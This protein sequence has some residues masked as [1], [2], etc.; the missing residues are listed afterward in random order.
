MRGQAF[1]EFI[2]DT[3]QLYLKEIV[4][5]GFLLHLR[6]CMLQC[7]KLQHHADHSFR[8][9]LRKSLAKADSVPAKERRI[10][11]RVSGLAAWRQ[12]I[13]RVAVESLWDEFVMI[14]APL[15]LVMVQKCILDVNLVTSAHLELFCGA[16]GQNRI[17][18][19]C[20]RS[21]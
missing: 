1:D 2:V 7:I 14:G 12:E 17:F 10:R 6:V 15:G 11:V 8:N 21:G 20:V 9:I 18:Y 16:L 13:L 5:E 3:W 4:R 19:H